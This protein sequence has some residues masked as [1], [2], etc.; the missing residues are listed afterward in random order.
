MSSKVYEAYYKTLGDFHQALESQLASPAAAPAAA[1]PTAAAQPP[2]PAASPV[3]A[4]PATAPATAPAAAAISAAAAPVASSSA[5]SPAAA[6]AAAWAAH[7]GGPSEGA[8]AAAATAASGPDASIAESV[9]SA[10]VEQLAD[11]NRKQQQEIATLR[12]DLQLTKDC[13]EECWDIAQEEAYA[14]LAKRREQ[15]GSEGSGGGSGGG[16]RRLAGARGGAAQLRCAAAVRLSLSG[17]R[18]AAAGIRAP[19]RQ[20]GSDMARFTQVLQAPLLQLFGAAGVAAAP[21][22][23]Q[24]QQQ[25]QQQQR[26]HGGH[27]ALPNGPANG[28]DTL[29]L[30]VT[31]AADAAL[32]AMGGGSSPTAAAHE[33]HQQQ[34]Q[35]QQQQH[36][37]QAEHV[38]RDAE[39]HAEAQSVLVRASLAE[40]EAHQQL[41]NTNVTGRRFGG[42]AVG[43]AFEKRHGHRGW[44]DARGRTELEQL[45]RK[46]RAAAYGYGGENLARL[47]AR[48]DKSRSGC[49][50]LGELHEVASRLLPGGALNDAEA[51][52]LLALLDSHGTGEI[53][54]DEFVAFVRAD[55]APDP[56]HAAAAARGQLRQQQQTLLQQEQQQ[57]QQQQQQRRRQRS[58]QRRS[59]QRYIGAARPGS[60]PRSVRRAPLPPPQSSSAH[61]ASPAQQRLGGRGGAA[62]ATSDGSGSAAQQTSRASRATFTPSRRHITDG[63]LEGI[64]EHLR[65][66]AAELGGAGVAALFAQQ[67]ADGS[68]DLSLGELH[69]AVEQL[70]GHGAAQAGQVVTAGAPH[71]IGKAAVWRL[72]SSIDSSQD[73]R[74][75]LAEF[76]AFLAAP[77]SMSG[78][79]SP[80]PAQRQ[81]PP[82]QQQQQQQQQQPV[83]GP[84]PAHGSAAPP[85]AWGLLYT[86]HTHTTEPPPRPASPEHGGGGVGVG[87]GVGGGDDDGDNPSKRVP[88]FAWVEKL[89]LLDMDKDGVLSPSE[90]RTAISALGIGFSSDEVRGRGRS[91]IQSMVAPLRRAA[92]TRCAAALL[93]HWL[94]S[95]YHHLTLAPPPLFLGRFA[96]SCPPPDQL[97]CSHAGRAPRRPHPDPRRGAR[98]RRRHGDVWAGDERAAQRLSTAAAPAAASSALGEENSGAPG[99]RAALVAAA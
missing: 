35:Q 47:F 22:A 26:W 79:P 67:D 77:G 83:G 94:Q 90:L 25:Q 4:P 10:V 2:A 15:E 53:S 56:E 3:P 27:T 8:A 65:T 42:L 91:M 52:R 41:T 45:R 43:A 62:G 64:K 54:L 76:T 85:S 38:L 86:L 32:A 21:A 13:I 37:Q 87:G 51:W 59:P 50:S 19:V 24:Q 58:P 36:V 33:Q 63:Q 28:S 82:Q 74:V 96:F 61:D 95:L 89:N 7:A 78:A 20:L 92:A 75:S 6:A 17:L 40:A 66:G 72:L 71:S 30:S 16:G 99:V 49:L 69:G 57:Q 23:Q 88:T 44:G 11:E 5:S 1:A 34:Q 55:D 70:L 98:A 84:L 81:W 14:D 48:L 60:P 31:A 80:P 39:R 68:G 12:E 9:L 18:E 73:G 29:G 97:H 46:L 93:F